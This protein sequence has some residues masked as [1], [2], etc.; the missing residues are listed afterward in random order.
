MILKDYIGVPEKT[1]DIN[2]DVED[3]IR[4]TGIVLDK[5]CLANKICG[6]IQEDENISYETALALILPLYDYD[7]EYLKTESGLRDN[8]AQN[9][10]VNQSFSIKLWKL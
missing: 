10:A 6:V 4:E 3:L 9:M 2:L 8:I 7:S 1:Y 5:I